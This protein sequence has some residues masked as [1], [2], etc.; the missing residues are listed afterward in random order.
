MNE[1]KMAI[2]K[3]FLQ[4]FFGHEKKNHVRKNMSE[5]NLVRKISWPKKFIVRKKLC[6]EL[7][8]YHKFTVRW[9][10][11]AP[12]IIITIFFDKLNL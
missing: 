11:K 7:T 12:I 4:E 9:F 6:S 5:K 10:R 8:D 3:N 2:I 1:E